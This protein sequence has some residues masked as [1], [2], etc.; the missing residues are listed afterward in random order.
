MHRMVC[1]GKCTTRN[2][3]IKVLFIEKDLVTAAS[4]TDVIGVRT[5][6]T[7]AAASIPFFFFNGHNV[8]ATSIK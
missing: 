5:I 6:W 1:V 2:D 4:G 3:E 8:I 7:Y